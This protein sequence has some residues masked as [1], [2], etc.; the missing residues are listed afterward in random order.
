MAKE[1]E[2][3][4]EEVKETPVAPVVEATEAAPEVVPMEEYRKLY[5]QAME[6]QT[7]FQRLAAAYNTLLENYISGK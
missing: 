6:L 2:V 4:M 1:K 3:V 5:E 7:K